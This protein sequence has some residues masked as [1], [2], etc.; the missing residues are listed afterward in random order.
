MKRVIMRLLLLAC[1]WV[2]NDALLAQTPSADYVTVEGVVRDHASNRRLENVNISVRGTNIGTV[3]NAEGTFVLKMSQT[4]ATAGIDVSHI[5]YFN[6]HIDLPIHFPAKLSV[7]LTPYT[8]L[9]HEVVVYGADNPRALVEKALGQIPL[10]YS[11]SR[12]LL[13]GFYRETAQKRH[14]YIS[15]SEA[16]MNILKTPYERRNVASDKVWILKGRRL[17]SQRQADTLAVKVMGGPSVALYLDLVKNDDA[18]LEPKELD[19]YDF[20][21]A[22]SV[23]IDNRLQYVVEFRPRVLQL[24]ALFYGKM[25]I[26]SE[27]L[28]FTRIEMSLDMQDRT[29]ATSAML[30]KK[31]ATLRFRP[32]EFSFLVTYKQVE[33]GTYLNYIRSTI[34]FKCDWKRRLFSTGYTIVTEMVVTDRTTATPANI[35]TAKAFSNR[36]VFYDKVGEYRDKHFWDAYNIIAPTES[37]EHAVGKLRKAP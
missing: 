23:L 3:T 8:N 16:V 25:Y 22:P 18:L 19:Y 5:G 11:N 17:L 12:E 7:R 35:P 21:L 28:S 32:Q 31:P 13:T 27:R 10:N 29:K 33:G 36:Q 6:R 37:L 34:R 26:D 24:Y 1:L 4:E 30:L 20:R 9:L 14:R 15:I 2:P